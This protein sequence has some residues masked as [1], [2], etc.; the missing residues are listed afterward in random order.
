MSSLR[1]SGPKSLAD[2]RMEW[3]GLAPYRHSQIESGLDSSFETVLAPMA[4][5]L[6]GQSERSRLL[7][8]GCGTGE[9]TALIAPQFETV[10]ALDPSPVSLQIADRSTPSNTTMR[11][12]WVEELSGELAVDPFPTVLAAMTLMTVPDLTAFASAVGS[13]VLPGGHLVATMTHPWFWPTYWHYAEE[14]WFDY[15]KE[16][17][18]EGPFRITAQETPCVTTH[19]HRPLE[20]Y[21]DAFANEGFVLEVLEEPAV[22]VDGGVAGLPRFI[23]LRWKKA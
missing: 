8:V 16:I 23:G 21:L 13:L 15:R 22:P 14:S 3:D 19:V 10:L 5:R 17:F 7:D 11:E 6:L 4:L 2:L 9:L 20:S 12:G 1:P 18:I